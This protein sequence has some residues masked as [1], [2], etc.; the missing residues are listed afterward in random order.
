MT[1]SPSSGSARI[2]L[3]GP[4]AIGC[5]VAA[6]LA[7]RGHEL[8]LASRSAFDTLRLQSTDGVSEFPARCARDPEELKGADLVV[9]AT[10]AHQTAAALPWLAAA[11]AGGTPILVAQN[12]VDHVERISTLL[13]G[14]HSATT[15]ITSALTSTIIPAVV[16]C[17]AHRLA[18]GHA[19]LEGRA[20]LIVPNSAAGQHV[21]GLFAGSFM[22]VDTTSDWTTAAWTKLLMNAALGPV[23]AMTGRP[24]GLLA[25]AGGRA[26]V[27]ALMDE[28]IAVGRA[29]G[30]QLA[31][32]VADKTIERSLA[33]ARDHLPSIAQDRLAGVPTE[34]V[35]R[36]EVIVRLGARYGVP[37]P[38]NTAM[39]TLMRLGEPGALDSLLPGSHHAGSSA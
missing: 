2:A 13:S 4:G 14:T 15:N 23:S 21:A 34:W 11:A 24:I 19:V 16:Y 20:Q 39:T 26:L 29:A 3:I 35:V 30:A 7:S 1:P 33:N 25:D 37:V 36:N 27:R 32:D 12:G 10:K 9:L 22:R 5:C 31:D 18:P 8:V 38:L 28:V 17:A 6:A